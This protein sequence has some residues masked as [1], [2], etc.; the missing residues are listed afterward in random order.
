M[1]VEPAIKCL[2]AFGFQGVQQSNTYLLL[3]YVFSSGASFS[4]IATMKIY[5]CHYLFVPLFIDI[6][7][8]S[9]TFEFIFSSKQKF[10][11]KQLLDTVLWTVK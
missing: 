1:G 6:F 2:M 11:L 10:F 3:Y 4:L 5:T 9:N 7:L 8:F